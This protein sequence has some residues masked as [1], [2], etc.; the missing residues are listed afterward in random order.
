MCLFVATGTPRRRTNPGRTTLPRVM[1]GAPSG[2][3][4]FVER[5]QNPGCEGRSVRLWVGLDHWDA[6][7]KRMKGGTLSFSNSLYIAV[8]TIPKNTI[9]KIWT[10]IGP[11]KVMSLS[12][13]SWTH[14]NA[15]T[16]ASFVYR[17]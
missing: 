15:N 4:S 5:V 6:K 11:S 8:D 9:T 7:N 17:R 14:R 13:T 12:R 3:T 1:L 16:P 10:R 2:A